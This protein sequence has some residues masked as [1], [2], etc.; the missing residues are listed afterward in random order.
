M[1]GAGALVKRLCEDGLVWS[2]DHR[3]DH[4][5]RARVAFAAARQSERSSHEGFVAHAACF[6][7]VAALA[8]AMQS[9]SI[10]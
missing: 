10:V 6:R 2:D 9:A 3:T 4:G 8:Y 1:L 5:I 7:D